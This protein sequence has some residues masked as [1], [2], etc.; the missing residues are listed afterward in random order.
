MRLCENLSSSICRLQSSTDDH[1]SLWQHSQ[2]QRAWKRRLRVLCEDQTSTTKA[3]QTPDWGLIISITWKA[4]AAL[5]RPCASVPPHSSRLLCPLLHQKLSQRLTSLHFPV[6][7][8]GSTASI[9]LFVNRLRPCLSDGMFWVD[10]KEL[11]KS[12]CCCFFTLFFEKCLEAS[13]FTLSW[14]PSLQVTH[15]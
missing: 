6:H 9:F 14:W 5:T 15:R 8:A 3:G 11:L 1:R 4:P 2:N 13:D 7:T 12:S 10:F